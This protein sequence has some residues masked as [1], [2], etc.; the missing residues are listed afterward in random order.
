MRQEF[1]RHDAASG[2]CGVSFTEVYEVAWKVTTPHCA[3]NLIE[4]E[5]TRT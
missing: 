1:Q 4:A 2:I 3:E 5:E